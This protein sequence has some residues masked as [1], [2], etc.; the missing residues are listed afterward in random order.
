MVELFVKEMRERE[1]EREMTYKD[2]P[3]HMQSDL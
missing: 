3:Y 2:V 1:R